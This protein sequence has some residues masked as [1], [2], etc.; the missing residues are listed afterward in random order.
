MV[1]A[2][3]D[4]EG[5]QILMDEDFNLSYNRVCVQHRVDALKECLLLL[6]SLMG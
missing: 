2:Y 5:L 1:K 6:T 3:S 4:A